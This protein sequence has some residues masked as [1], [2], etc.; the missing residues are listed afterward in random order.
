MKKR[1]MWF[2]YMFQTFLMTATVLFIVMGASAF[3]LEKQSP[4]GWQ[5]VV[6]LIVVGYLLLVSSSTFDGVERKGLLSLRQD[7]KLEKLKAAY[8]YELERAQKLDRMAE[9]LR[10]QQETNG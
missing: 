8:E 5:W 4:K 2:N 9:A 10:E 1:K 6:T 3:Y 7:R